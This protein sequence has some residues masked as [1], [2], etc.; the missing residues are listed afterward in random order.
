MILGYD[1]RLTRY[2]VPQNIVMSLASHIIGGFMI[3]MFVPAHLALLPSTI[4]RVY[5][6]SLSYQSY[7]S[8]IGSKMTQLILNSIQPLSIAVVFLGMMVFKA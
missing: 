7:S 6:P 2:M 1:C 4:I 3:H 8:F 5:C